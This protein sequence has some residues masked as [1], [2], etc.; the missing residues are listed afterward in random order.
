MLAYRQGRLQGVRYDD[1]ARAAFARAAFRLVDEYESRG[2]ENRAMRI[3]ELVIASGVPAAK[4][5]EKRLD[6]IQMRGKFL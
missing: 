2:Q 1:D 3:L 4:E 5:A 6:R